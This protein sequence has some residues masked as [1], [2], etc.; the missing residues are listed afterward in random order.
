MN[1]IK[2]WKKKERKEWENKLDE[3]KLTLCELVIGI[4]LFSMLE[5]IVGVFFINKI[6]C[7]IL[8]II[9]GTL[10][11]IVIVN[12]MYSTIDKA[13][14]AGEEAA[15]KIV[16]NGAMLRILGI[17]T[18]F[19]IVVYLH[20]YINVYAVFISMLNLKF[21]AYIQPLTNKL[22]SCRYLKGR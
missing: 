13:I 14:E 2:R 6:I 22:I 9:V 12:H 5:L 17:F 3:S 20:K 18:I 21:S 15:E 4:V 16:R 10:S 1:I 11:A 19:F 7:F 8:G